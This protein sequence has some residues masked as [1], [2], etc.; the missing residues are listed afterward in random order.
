LGITGPKR[1]GAAR[2]ETGKTFAMFRK[3]TD[4]AA[5]EYGTSDRLMVLFS[6]K[7]AMRRDAFDYV[8]FVQGMPH[9]KLY[10]RDAESDYLYHKGIV[11]MTDS[12]QETVDFLRVFIKRMKPAR[13][14]FMGMS[15]GAYAAGL[16]GYLVGADPATRVDDVH[17]QSAV[18]YISPEVRDRLGGGERFGGLFDML[19]AFTIERNEDLTWLDLR[20]VIKAN[21]N[22]VGVTRLYYAEGDQ[23]DSMHA[24]HLLGLP[25]VQVVPHPTHSHMMLG[26]TVMREGTLFRDIDTPIETLASETPSA[27]PVPSAV[28]AHIGNMMKR[29]A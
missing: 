12:V 9:T 18:T 25:R 11:G 22:S 13:V 15:G 5:I 7:P 2:S 1:Q 10:L 28:P 16:F 24:T 3:I 14:T 4:C 29:R 27:A 19:K 6:S 23:I 17:L 26:S 21:P 8:S 20:E